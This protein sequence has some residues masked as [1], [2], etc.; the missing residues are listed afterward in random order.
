MWKAISIC[1]KKGDF[2]L[3]KDFVMHAEKEKNIIII[4]RVSLK[5][6]PVYFSFSM[7]GKNIGIWFNERLITWRL[8]CV[9]GV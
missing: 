8:L 4:I 1:L 7:I 3:M 6:F 5:L 2:V 9:I